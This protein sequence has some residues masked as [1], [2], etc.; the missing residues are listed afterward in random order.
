MARVRFEDTAQGLDAAVSGLFD[1]FGGAT[2]LLKRSKDV[3][4]K[5]NGIDY[6]PHVYTSPEVV[7]ASVRYFKAHGAR[8]IYVMENSTQGN[9]TRL[10]YEITGMK[11][12]CEETGAIPI[13]LDETAEMPLYLQKLE[14]FINIPDFIHE[15]LIRKRGD[16][17]Y[18]SM[19]KLKSHSMTTVTLGIKNQFGLVHQKSRIADHNFKLHQ[20]LADIYANIRPDFTLIDGIEATNFGHYP[21]LSQESASVVPMHVLIGGGDPMAVNVVGAK[22]LGFGLE[23]VQH[24]K[25]AAE[26]GFGE[27]QFERITIENRD[28]FDGRK[29]QFSWDL[30]EKFPEGVRIIRGKTLCCRE[31]CKRNT[32]AVLEVFGQDFRGKGGF[33]ILM[34]KGIDPAEVAGITGPV[35]IAG[36]CAMAEWYQELKARLGKRKVTVSPGCNNLAKTIDGLGKHMKIPPIR[37]VPINPLRSLALLLEAHLHGTK[38]NITNA[39]RL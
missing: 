35:H 1:A 33:T 19:P 28:L 39:F 30:L 11:R 20:K 32:E 6:K 5:V 34:G 8:N 24:L 29:Q 18:I 27:S 13:Y 37:L 4:I 16:N 17:L 22:F 36:D 3:Y 21:A 12:M 10:V 2:S 14:S 23:E 26:Y 15:N 7:A 9:F 31:G 25:L 38:A